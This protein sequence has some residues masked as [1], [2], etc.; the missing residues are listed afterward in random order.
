MPR[1]TTHAVGIDCEHCGAGP[2]HAEAGGRVRCDRCGRFATRSSA[3]CAKHGVNV[4]QLRSRSD[5]PKC[6]QERDV[7][8]R[9]R[10]RQARRANPNM[11]NMVDAQANAID[12]SRS[13]SDFI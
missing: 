12:H 9:E 6:R 2:G 7:Q 10:E 13:A 11:H 8:A 1:G 5:C 4:R 3:Y